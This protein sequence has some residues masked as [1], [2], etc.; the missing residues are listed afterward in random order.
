MVLS[1]TLLFRNHLSVLGVLLL[2]TCLTVR[3]GDAKSHQD[4]GWEIFTNALLSYLSSNYEKLVF[5]LWGKEAKQKGALIEQY[6]NHL[7]LEHCHPSPMARLKGGGFQGCKHFSECNEYLIQHNKTPIDWNWLPTPHNTLPENWKCPPE[8]S[9]PAQ[10]DWACNRGDV[11]THWSQVD[12]NWDY[13]PVYLPAGI[14]PLGE[15]PVDWSWLYIDW[16][17]L[18]IGGPK[19]PNTSIIAPSNP[20][21]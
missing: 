21:L 1:M 6:R 8:D 2:N 9:S 19:L 12:V 11:R 3:E 18:P 4:K 5:M 20:G 15:R 10:R 14:D 13:L 7:I 16:T 17:G